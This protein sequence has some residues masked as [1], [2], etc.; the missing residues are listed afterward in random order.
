[1]HGSSDR[2]TSTRNALLA[3]F[4]VAVVVL[5][6]SLL[7]W[8]PWLS[9]ETPVNPY[10]PATRGAVLLARTSLRPGS[11]DSVTLTGTAEGLVAGKRESVRLRFDRTPR[12][13]VFALRKQWPSDGTWMLVI[14]LGPPSVAVATAIVDMTPGGEVATVRVPQIPHR[15]SRA[16]R[17]SF[18][19][20]KIS[21][22]ARPRS[23]V[24]QDDVRGFLRCCDFNALVP[25]SAQVD[26]FEKPL[27]TAEQDWRDGN[28][29]LIYEALTQILLDC[30]GPTANAHVSIRGRLSRQVQR[31]SNSVRDEVERRVA[32]HADGWTRMVSQDEDRNVV[33]GTVSPPSLPVHVRPGAANRSEHVSPE[34]PCADIPKSACGEVVVDPGCAAFLAKQG[35]L[36]RACREQPLVQIGPANAERVVEILVRAC[37][38]SIER[39][40]ETV[41]ANSCHLRSL[42]V[43]V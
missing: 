9:I 7:A 33:R 23:L 2:R 31:L 24:P 34:N 21:P 12:A 8:P 25:E 42:G 17:S 36:E 4:F 32:F 16:R 38:V 41:N 30:I 43:D 10:D 22:R 11:T 13:G 6:A 3:L 18:A 14:S 28:V 35:P 1:M 39:D 37:S 27:S 15:A 40:G 26:S 20:C 29:Q 5:P 19:L